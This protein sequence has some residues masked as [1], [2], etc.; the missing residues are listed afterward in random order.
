MKMKRGLGFALGLG[1]VLGSVGFVSTAHAEAMP[2]TCEGLENCAVVTNAE[3]LAEFFTITDGYRTR[4][5][6]STMIIGGDF[7][8]AADYYIKD[9]VLSIYLGEH[10]IT[11]AD[12]S[13]LFYNSTV[14]I[15]S[16]EAG[17][18]TAEGV[19]WT[20]LF[21]RDNSNVTMYGGTITGGTASTVEVDDGGKFALEDGEIYGETWVVT[22]FNDSEFVMNGGALTTTGPDSIGVSGNGT[23][24]PTKDNYGANAKITINGGTITSEDL[25]VYAPQVG[26]LTTI[27]EGATINAKKAGVEIRAGELVVNGATINVDENAEYTFN[28]N[29]SGSTASGVG[30]AVAQHTTKQAITATVNSAVVTAP[31]AFAE[32]NPQHNPGEDIA[33]VSLLIKDGTF[34]ATNGEPIVA[35]EDVEGFVE[36]GFYSKEIEE[37]YIKE[38][39][40]LFEAGDDFV[41][42]KMDVV[43]LPEMTLLVGETRSLATAFENYSNTSVAVD[44]TGDLS[45]SGMVLTAVKSGAAK[46]MVTYGNGIYRKTTSE[47][48]ASVIDLEKDLT[49]EADEELGFSAEEIS[50]IQEKVAEMIENGQYVSEDGAVS[51]VDIE[52]L[53]EAIANGETIRIEKVVEEIDPAGLDE[54]GLEQLAQIIGEN[55]T[56]VSILSIEYAMFGDNDQVLGR[57]NKLANPVTIEFVVPEGMREAAEGFTRKF[58]VVRFHPAG[59]EEQ[60]TRL[61]AEFDGEKAS[62]ENDLFSVFILTYQDEENVVTPGTGRFTKETEDFAKSSKSYGMLVLAMGMIVLGYGLVLQGKKYKI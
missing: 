33:K 25:G 50:E 7:T 30:I 55:D 14:D 11:M 48:Q 54:E 20:P 31:V 9:V 18:M 15:Y 6:N 51:V 13:F 61:A 1:V 22:V 23:A 35:S 49:I 27:G 26:G 43:D 39:Y 46:Y 29:G 56:P 53:R 17:G 59:V 36:G 57:V 41:V 62:V 52:A 24:D 58:T 60:I 38:G 8:M 12:Y 34:T 10:T 44:D 45:V 4:E 5:G 16:G 21:V 32:G 37:K 3:E 19:Y 42:N 40:D 28:P 2:T 47:Y